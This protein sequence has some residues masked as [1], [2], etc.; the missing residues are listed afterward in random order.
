MI[1]GWFKKPFCVETKAKTS[2]DSRN[3]FFGANLSDAEFK[4]S[5]WLK[6]IE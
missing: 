2:P 1:V 4:R 3:I 5:G 6:I